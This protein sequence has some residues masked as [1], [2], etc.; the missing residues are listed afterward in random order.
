MFLIK[1]KSVLND[2]LEYLFIKAD[3]PNK[4]THRLRSGCI[5]LVALNVLLT[6]FSAADDTALDTYISEHLSE[7]SELACQKPILYPASTVYSCT[8]I[9]QRWSEGA[10][11]IEGEV[12]E[13]DIT[14]A[15][16]NN[17][18]HMPDTAFYFIDDGENDRSGSGIRQ[19][20]STQNNAS[21]LYRRKLHSSIMID[22]IVKETNAI[23]VY[24]QQVPN[25]PYT[26]LD[27]PE[28]S[29]KENE[30]L[31]ES[32]VRAVALNTIEPASTLLFPMAEAS[33]AGLYKAIDFI[34]ANLIADPIK[35]FV[36]GGASKRAWAAW[37]A[38]A[39]DQ[40]ENEQARQLISAVVP[41]A[42]IQNF[43]ETLSA[44]QNSYCYF[45]KPFSSFT[46]R[47]IFQELLA[48]DNNRYR[49]LFKLIDPYYYLQ[50]FSNVHSMVV[51]TSSDSFFI[52][53]ATHYYYPELKGNKNMMI[54]PSMSHGGSIPSMNYMDGI[55]TNL[56]AI[57]QGDPLPN[58]QEEYDHFSN[59]L[60]LHSDQKPNHV[61]VWSAN[62]PNTRD[63]RLKSVKFIRAEIQPIITKDDS[64]TYQWQPDK[65][66]GWTAFF[67]EIHYKAQGKKS[68]LFSTQAYVTP[69]SYPACINY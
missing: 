25:Q 11:T 49:E 40:G 19:L 5:V 28:A 29:L 24:Q 38:T 64:F 34:N 65:Q 31:A 17:K 22:M 13:H 30:L 12:W 7:A 51:Q 45:P 57:I 14:I 36:I 52:P 33:V 26:F 44:I 42:M 67:M 32:L 69:D 10:K 3:R 41:I 60:T 15:I 6:G 48:S 23:V 63:F 66:T 21:M 43:P 4:R 47:N 53:D 1:I 39:F 18:K 16:P 54:L 58:Y 68:F 62:N 20:M 2:A 55:L 9:S 8:F 46:N 50:R 56:S 27:A 35:H 59:T 61:Y 37:L